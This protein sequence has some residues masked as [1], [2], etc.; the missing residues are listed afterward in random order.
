STQQTSGYE[1]ARFRDLTTNLG[2][3]AIRDRLWFFTGYQ[4]LRDYDS[5]PG[6]DPKRPRTYEQNKM[7]AKLT[8]QLAPGWQLVQMVHEEI[9]VSPEQP[10]VAKPFDA[11]L[12]SHASVP[13]MTFGNLTHTV[14]ANTV[15]DVRVGRFVY[16]REDDPSTG[17]RTTPGKF[18]RATTVSSG[19]P[20]TFGGRTLTR[21]NAKATLN[22]YRPV[23]WGADHQWKIGGQVEQG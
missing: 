1:R 19:A 8:W 14:S 3:P 17:N 20:Q 12:R 16:S 7:M 5:Q 21:T 22:H 23:L 6:T 18:D 11:T 15:W 4:Y 9:W 10:T 13:A 2:G